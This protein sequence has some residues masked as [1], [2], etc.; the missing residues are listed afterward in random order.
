MVFASCD[1]YLCHCK[2]FV[3]FIFARL[4]IAS[5]FALAMTRWLA[6][7]HCEHYL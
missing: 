7:R 4:W 6:Y 3:D 2:A 5:G 1:S